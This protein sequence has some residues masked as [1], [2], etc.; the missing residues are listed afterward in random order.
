METLIKDLKYYL[1]KNVVKKIRNQ[2]DILEI[3]ITEYNAKGGESY[4]FTSTLHLVP[5]NLIDVLEILLW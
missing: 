4:S 3:P 1:P 2:Q 5:G